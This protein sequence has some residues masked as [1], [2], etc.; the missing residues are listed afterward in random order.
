MKN[1]QKSPLACGVVNEMNH[2]VAAGEVKLNKKIHMRFDNVFNYVHCNFFPQNG[3]ISYLYIWKDQL[4][5][6]AQQGTFS[7]GTSMNWSQALSDINLWAYNNIAFNTESTTVSTWE[8]VII[9]SFSS[10]ITNILD[11][12]RRSP[13][14][15]WLWSVQR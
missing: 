8:N 15:E 7:C 1:R 2:V 9:H 10:E 5:S 14:S 3:V 11:K 6:A 4:Y 12:L 13:L